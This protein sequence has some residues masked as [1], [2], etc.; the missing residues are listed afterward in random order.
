MQPQPLPLFPLRLRASDPGYDAWTAAKAAFKA[1]LIAAYDR[2][3]TSLVA[4]HATAVRQEEAEAEDEDEDKEGD[5]QDRAAVFH[6]RHARL[7]EG[8]RHHIASVAA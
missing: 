8:F 1:E 6:R 7:R 5:I 2:Q 3:V 4:D